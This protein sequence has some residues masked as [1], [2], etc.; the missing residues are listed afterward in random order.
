MKLENLGK[1]SKNYFKKYE[2]K[3]SKLDT[4]DI[5]SYRMNKLYSNNGVSTGI[6]VTA[7]TQHRAEV[8]DSPMKIIDEEDNVDVKTDKN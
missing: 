8:G 2:Q 7:K 3:N 5:L 4:D 6:Q 1:V